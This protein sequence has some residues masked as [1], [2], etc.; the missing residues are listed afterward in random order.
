M[1]HTGFDPAH[2]VYTSLV[3][4]AQAPGCSVGELSKVGPGLH[5]LP[6]SKLLRF[7]FLGTPQRH[8]L[9][10]AC[11]LCP[12]C[13]PCRIPGRLGWQLGACSQFSGGCHLWGQ[14]CPLPSG[15][16]CCCLPLCLWQE[17]G[18]S[19]PGQLSSGIHLILCSVSRPGCSLGQCFLRQSSL[20]PSLSFSFLSLTIIQF[21]LLSHVSSLR[22]S[23][24]LFRPSPQ[25]S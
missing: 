20:S 11:V 17:D 23:S 21:G 18:Q 4:T 16:G 24:G 14:D 2:S 12:S 7:R 15:S 13:Q 19:T 10:W 5:V 6:R 3:Y 9:G 1:G 25:S 22:L 8:R